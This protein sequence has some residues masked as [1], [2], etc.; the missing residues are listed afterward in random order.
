M[1]KL[2]FNG[3]FVPMTAPE[4]TFEALLVA[5]DGTIAFTGSLEEAR[6]LAEGCEEVDL[7]GKAVMPGFIDPHGHFGMTNMLLATADLSRCQS[8]DDILDALVKFRD[9]HN[10]GPDEMLVGMN[11]DHNELAEQRHPNKFDL[12]KV[13]ATQPIAVY[14]ASCHM[15]AAN[16]AL[17]DLAGIDENTD[18]VEGARY[19]RVG[20]TR[21][22]NGY[23]EETAAMLPVHVKVLSKLDCSFDSMIDKMQDF[24]A[25]Y[26]VTTCQE[27]ATDP[28]MCAAFT[29]LGE[30]GRMKIDLVMYPMS[31]YDVPGMLENYAAYDAPT[32]KGHVRIGG[33]KTVL[34]GSPQGR[35]A[36]LSE[37]YT[38]GEEGEGFCSNGFKSDEEVYEF[39]KMAIDTN[40]D[41]LAHANGDET[42]EQ[43]LRCYGKAY[44][45][46]E[47]PEKDKLR[48]V[49][50]H[51][52][53]ARTDQ[54]ERMGALNM[55]PSIFTSHIWYWGDV[56]LKN[57][58]PVRGSRVSAVRDALD[59][60]LPFTFH[61][62][63]PI[64][65]P[66]MLETVWCAVNRITKRGAQLDESQK[67]G[68]FD[69][70]KAITINGAY[71]YHEEDTK[72]TLEPGKLADLVILNA[73]P[74]AV[75]PA[76]I[77]DITVLETV[78]EGDTV[79]TRA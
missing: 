40:H 74:L 45:D 14:H 15:M 77:R 63:C 73:S 53:T 65:P 37:P 60:N 13:S 62:D 34:D 9:E 26:G 43:I 67:V 61:T 58:G 2:Y 23:I 78:K 38:L 59:N 27:G 64:L 39:A 19:Y 46:S 49:M 56:H 51:C 5:D 42:S 52:Q 20:D 35:T 4:D 68:V 10:M 66:D 48:P 3:T 24:Y 75:D 50:I 33:V 57:F 54:Y 1:K 18:D 30:Q 11:Y 28:A 36:W 72:G 7:E 16:S 44:A 79:F 22:P 12:D 69:A 25:S 6:A 76:A 55:V 47:N 70:L 29:G 8:I 41:W 17:L 21:E 71:Q 32:Y 31:S